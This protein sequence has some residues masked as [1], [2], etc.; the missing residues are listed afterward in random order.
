MCGRKDGTYAKKIKNQWQS[1][2]FFKKIKPVL[3]DGKKHVP[4]NLQMRKQKVVKG[5]FL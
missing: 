3:E 1:L 5:L 4:L 2:M